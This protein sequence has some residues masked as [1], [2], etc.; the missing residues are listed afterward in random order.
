[1]YF[2]SSSII[3]ILYIEVKYKMN[4]DIDLDQ[5]NILANEIIVISDIILLKAAEN[6]VKL[7]SGENSEL[8]LETNSLNIIGSLLTLIGDFA[9]VRIS[10][11]E[12][13]SSSEPIS[14][15]TREDITGGWITVIGDYI[16]AKVAIDEANE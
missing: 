9:L 15:S 11:V 8:E 6:E 5:L 16:A 12:A 7:K 14:E 13:Y 10:E 1:M 4:D 3:R 2:N